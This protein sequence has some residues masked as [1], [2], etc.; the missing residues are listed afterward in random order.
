MEERQHLYF[1]RWF[2]ADSTRATQRGAEQ[3]ANRV[4]DGWHYLSGETQHE[5]K[6]TL[7]HNDGCK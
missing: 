1:L 4:G 2:L 5:T 3:S 6:V 7:I